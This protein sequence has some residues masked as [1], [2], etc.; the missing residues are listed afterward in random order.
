MSTKQAELQARKYLASIGH[1]PSGT[2]DYDRAL[3]KAAA[4]IEQL[5]E[6]VRLAEQNNSVEESSDLSK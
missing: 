3:R 6:A 5:Q 2:V 1:S 4:S